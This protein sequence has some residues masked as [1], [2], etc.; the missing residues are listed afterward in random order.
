MD[1]KPLNLDTPHKSELTENT[2]IPLGVAVGC[3]VAMVGGAIWLNSNLHAIKD[4]IR[5]MRAEFSQNM[6][7]STFQIWVLELK[8]DN[9]NLKVP[10]LHQ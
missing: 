2:R 1:D 3:T 5:A 7:K 6:N 4:E 10:N 9:P 8:A